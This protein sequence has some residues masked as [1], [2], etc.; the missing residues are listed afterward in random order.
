MSAVDHPEHYSRFLKEIIDIVEFFPF[1]AGNAIK[2]ISRAPYKGARIEDLRK[3]L[4]YVERI[5]K[6]EAHKRPDFD[7]SAFADLTNLSFQIPDVYERNAVLMIAQS[8]WTFAAALL[9]ER[10]NQ[11]EQEEK[12]E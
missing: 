2:Y 11:L 10:I 12:K 6:Q 8:N 7:R 1:C 5:Q 3:A 4:W 9:I